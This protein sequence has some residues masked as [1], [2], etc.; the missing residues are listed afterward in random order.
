[1]EL[2]PWWNEAKS[3]LNKDPFL[4]DVITRYPDE[5]L[6]LQNEPF[7][8]LARAIIG[9]QI[10]VTAADTVWKRL[11]AICDGNVTACRI[12][13]F[14]V[15]DL[16]SVGCSFR[17]GEYLIH[18]AER[19]GEFLE[20]GFDE[21]DSV[22]IKRLTTLR[23]VGPWTAKMFLIFALGKPDVFPIGDIGLIR[24]LQQV[25]PE[26]VNMESKEMMMFA[27]RWKPWRTAVTW[28]LWRVIDPEPVAY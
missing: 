14:T 13:E 5:G 22:L 21:E 1:M 26:T 2:V 17:K 3:V 10:S 11:E 24:G 8:T 7:V 28:Y 19:I 15:D 20:D 18:V 25:V 16:R 4:T 6:A 12:L 27:E 23:G 9:Q